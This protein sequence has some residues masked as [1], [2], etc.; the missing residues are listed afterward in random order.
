MKSFLNSKSFKALCILLCALL[1]GM[2]VAAV[3]GRGE[4]AQTTVVG[5]IF[6]PIQRAAAAVTKKLN[7]AFGNAT[8]RASYIDKIK[9]QEA[10]IGSLQQDL[11][12][13]ENVK[14]QNA[15]YKDILELKEEKKE[16][17][18]VDCSV[19]AR[20]KA[21]AFYAFSLNKGSL[22]G[23]KKGDA[24]ISGKYLVGL[25][26]EVYPDYSVVR[27]MLDPKVSVAVYE[28]VSTEAA[29]TGGTLELAKQGQFHIALMSGS[30][31]I[32]DG[33]LICTSGLGGGVT[34][35]LIVGT[36]AQLQSSQTDI[37]TY[38]IIQP[39]VDI[40]TLSDVVVIKGAGAAN[41]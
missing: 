29:Y 13:Y 35:G 6:S 11:A 1:L 8:G 12:D 2:T 9:E 41:E 39:G 30:S 34:D 10:Q 17:Q 19:I 4:T 27:T 38:A 15:L 24:V 5:T 28:I 22:S 23:I 33:A 40:R 16:L 7:D 20:E 32:S 31:A 3:N 26:D 18:F 37:S 14:R 36:V 25:V 21:E